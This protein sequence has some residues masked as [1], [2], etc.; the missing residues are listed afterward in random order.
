M[1]SQPVPRWIPLGGFTL[2]CAAGIINAVGFLGVGHE[3]LSHMS[4]NVSL[5]GLHTAAG[6]APLAFRAFLLVLCFFA[7]SL[8]SGMIVRQ[9]TLKLG[10]PYG[11]ALGVESALLI[12]ATYFL[13]HGV[14]FGD[15]L[16]AMACGLQNALATT[17]SGA[18]IRT[19]HITGILTDVGI[20]I[21]HWARRHAVDWRRVRLYLVLLAGFTVGG[22]LGALSFQRW[23]YDT[24][25]IP[26]ALVAVGAVASELL[27]R[28]ARRAQTP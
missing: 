7:G 23:R 19:T 8:L 18:V 5:L 27:A 1:F 3:A 4:G 2:T 16:A 22:V 9:N 20:A 13:R 11:V 12:G 6:A 28:H 15:Y 25:L 14:T 17:Y 21:G 24:L 26:A 10:R